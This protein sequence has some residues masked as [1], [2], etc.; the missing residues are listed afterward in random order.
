VT[1]LSS[2]E[3]SRP[4]YELVGELLDTFDDR[5]F[6]ILEGRKLTV[7]K[8]TLDSLGTE[9]GLTRERIR[10]IEQYISA[11]IARW[12]TEVPEV[13]SH[14][15]LIRRHVQRLCPLE[16]LL[17]A[18]PALAEK[19]EFVELPSWFVFDQF[20]DT[21]E[22]DG[23]WV[24]VPSLSDVWAQ[25][26]ALFDEYVND[27]GYVETDLVH[28][29]LADWGS[30]TPS[31]I[32][33]WA[34]EHGYRSLAGILVSPRIR[35]M[36]ALAVAMLS[37]IGQPTAEREL[38]QV[39][40][41]QA[42]PRSFANQL[43]ADDRLIRVGADRWALASWGGVEYR[44]IRDAIL[45]LVDAN[46][47]ASLA[48]LIRDLPAE[49]DVSA[50]SVRTYAT[51][52]P[53]ETVG[54]TV[55]RATKPTTPNRP[56]HRGRGVTFVN[57]GSAYRLV[58]NLDNMRGSGFPIPSPLAGALGIQPGQVREFT[59]TD[60][61][62]AVTI[63]WKQAQPQVSSIRNN[64]L[65][66]GANVGHVVALTFR[67]GVSN[68]ETR[69]PLSVEPGQAIRQLLLLDDEIPLTTSSMAKALG[70]PEA[71]SWEELL[72]LAQLRRETE[73]V[74]ALTAVSNTG[75]I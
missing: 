18:Q 35:S 30:A 62:K 51:S 54:D 73:L 14:S 53:L 4:V 60:D 75:L 42:S 38:H 7:P 3:P 65:R 58:V 1:W 41:P 23:R 61:E 31:Q 29:L 57:G 26:E 12:F 70:L 28:N 56:L 46:G 44:G 74:T 15:E 69:G 5:E 52:W 32:V 45:K 24:A 13:A 50:S 22:S 33:D 27:A 2:L 11:E 40:A 68:V 55:R 20:D 47:S 6:R 59:P 71:S 10:Q 48:A 43:A 16:S 64:L 39:V 67:D 17:E 72:E 19:I 21:F 63:R 8:E 25:F 34:L 49:F 37:H 9:F 66:L 36:N